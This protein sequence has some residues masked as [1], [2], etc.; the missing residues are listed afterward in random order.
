MLISRWFRNL[1][2]SDEICDS[3]FCFLQLQRKLLWRDLADFFSFTLCPEN[4]QQKKVLENISNCNNE[5]QS[6]PVLLT[7]HSEGNRMKN[8]NVPS[9]DSLEDHLVHISIKSNSTTMMIQWNLSLSLNRDFL[10][11]E[12][13]KTSSR[14]HW[15]WVMIS[16]C[17]DIHTGT[18]LSSLVSVQ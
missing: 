14:P 10:G 3:S 8:L 6:I 9:C 11:N 18:F 5:L 13:E 16:H 17:Y 4:K 2:S 15:E 1:V 7:Q 12:L